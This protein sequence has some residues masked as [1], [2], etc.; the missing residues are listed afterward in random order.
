MRRRKTSVNVVN[1]DEKTLNKAVFFNRDG[2]FNCDEGFD[3]IYRQEDVHFHAGVVEVLQKLQESGYR[4]FMVTNRVGIAKRICTHD[5]D[6]EVN[7]RIYAEFG[8]N[9]IC[10]T[11]LYHCPH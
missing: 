4:L 11:G 2:T 1:P 5:L 8:Q 7:D 3:Y 6:K 10:I 9:A